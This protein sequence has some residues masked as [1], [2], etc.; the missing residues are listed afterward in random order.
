MEDNCPEFPNPSQSDI[1]AGFLGAGDACD[2]DMD[3]DG[4]NNNLDNC[5]YVAN[6]GQEDSNSKT[7]G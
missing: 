7:E 1:D 6:P 5:P 3:G 2:E 4:V